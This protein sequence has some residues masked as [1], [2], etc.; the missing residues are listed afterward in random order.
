MRAANL[1]S[2]QSAMFVSLEDVSVEQGKILCDT[3]FFYFS[4]LFAVDYVVVFAL[5]CGRKLSS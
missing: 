4:C 1:Q 5:Y 3:G 2:M